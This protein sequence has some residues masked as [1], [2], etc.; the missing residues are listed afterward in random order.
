MKRARCI[1]EAC[2]ALAPHSIP[3]GMYT[4]EE[5]RDM[6]LIDVT[7]RETVEQAV[8]AAAETAKGAMPDEDFDALVDTLDVGSRAELAAA[9]NAGWKRQHEMSAAQKEKFRQWRNDTL[10]GLEGGGI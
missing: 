5:T 1:S 2:R 3:L 8:A 9:F 4:V 10:A 7:P 6:D